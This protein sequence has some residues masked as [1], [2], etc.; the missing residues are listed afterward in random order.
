[1]TRRA[2]LDDDVEDRI[3]DSDP[4]GRWLT[5]EGE[6]LMQL[7]G[8]EPAVS[9]ATKIAMDGSLWTSK[10]PPINNKSERKVEKT[11]PP[12]VPK[13]SDDEIISFD[14]IADDVEAIS[15]E[16]E[17]EISFPR[18]ASAARSRARTGPSSASMKT[19]AARCSSVLAAIIA[20]CSS[21]H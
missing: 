14:D 18:S 7:A 4:E 16:D 3:G 5:A 17:P 11:K 9:L 19:A 2:H 10:K 12:R 1:M 15:F 21:L 6:R 8:R 20:R 13:P